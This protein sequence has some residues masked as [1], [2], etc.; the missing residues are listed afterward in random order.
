MST[1]FRLQTFFKRVIYQSDTVTVYDN[2]FYRWLTLSTDIVQ[3]IVFN[4][5]PSRPTMPYLKIFGLPAIHFK[6]ETGIVGLGG[7]AIVHYLKHAHPTLH[8]SICENQPE[9]ID[10][11]KKLFYLNQYDHL[12]YE[13]SDL[14]TFLTPE[15]QPKF[16]HLLID[17]YG[18]N[19][20]PS[21]GLTERFFEHC[22]HALDENGILVINLPDSIHHPLIH[23]GLKSLFK[24]HPITFPVKHFDNQ[25]IMVMKSDMPFALSALFHQHHFLKQLLYDEHMGC[26]GAFK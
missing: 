25:I 18:K 7:G 3:T 23:Q 8:L 22:F 13:S 20:Y 9:V 6:G 12:D 21:I 14:F 1:W 15:R 11:A 2:F 24:S 10:V 5:Q 26:I 17:I 16:K 19:A 4:C